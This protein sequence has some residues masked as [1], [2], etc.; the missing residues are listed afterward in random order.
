MA[1]PRR[2]TAG[3]L[4]AWNCPATGCGKPATSGT[5]RTENHGPYQQISIRSFTCP[6]RHAWTHQTDGG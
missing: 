4:A 5:Y 3:E 6:S 1:K 2:L